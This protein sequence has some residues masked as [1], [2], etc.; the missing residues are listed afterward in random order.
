MNSGTSGLV[1]TSPP[2]ASRYG[3]GAANRPDPPGAFGADVHCPGRI[4][5]RRLQHA[6]P[7]V[8]ILHAFL[9]GCLLTFIDDEI[10][11]QVT[12]TRR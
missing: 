7:A 6:A 8:P 1:A 9:S 5:P 3:A 10:N 12:D 4:H 2:P 11:Y